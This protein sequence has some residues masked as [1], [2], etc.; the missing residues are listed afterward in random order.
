MDEKI[1]VVSICRD[2]AI[3]NAHPY[4]FDSCTGDVNRDGTVTLSDAVLLAHVIAED[5]G[6]DVSTAGIFCADCNNDGMIRM[7]DMRIVLEYIMY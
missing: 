2:T 6:T 5:S 3:L 4:P 7:D 1:P